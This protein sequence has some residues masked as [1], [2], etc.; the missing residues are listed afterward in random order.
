MLQHDHEFKDQERASLPHPT[1]GLKPNR[2]LCTVCGGEQYHIVLVAKALDEDVGLVIR[3]ENC[4]AS[5]EMPDGVP[6]SPQGSV[7]SLHEEWSR[8]SKKL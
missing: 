7:L 8:P 2:Y 1:S 6:A 5:Q 4:K 3:C